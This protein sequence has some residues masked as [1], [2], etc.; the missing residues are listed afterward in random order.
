MRQ[1]QSAK[2]EREGG[3]GTGEPYVPEEQTSAAGEN[4]ENCFAGHGA[5]LLH[6][7]PV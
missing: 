4:G 2:E 7:V 1:S 5:V 3:R 6:S